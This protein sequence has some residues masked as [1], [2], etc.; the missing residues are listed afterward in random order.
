MK[1]ILFATVFSVV[2]SLISSL[3]A[4]AATPQEQAFIDSYKKALE[5]N[6]T[7]TLEGLL[8]TKDADPEKLAE[9]KES[10]SLAEGMTV[11]QVELVDVTSQEITQAM[12]PYKGPDGKMSALTVKPAK[13]LIVT[14]A[15]V[16]DST[17]SFT[18]QRAVG[19]IDG[20]LLILVPSVVKR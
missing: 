9:I 20:K 4:F 3:S 16:E 14:L 17:F 2:V 18:S 12:T 1:Q 13:K 10:L 5:A 6:D 19:D 15:A 8:Y 11:S 7:K